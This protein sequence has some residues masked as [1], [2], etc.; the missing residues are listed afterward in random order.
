MNPFNGE[1][2][3]MRDRDLSLESGSH[4]IQKFQTKSLHLASRF[5]FILCD[6]EVSNILG[7]ILGV[8]MTK[9]KML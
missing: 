4:F 1:S 5:V 6:N 8:V 2:V 9:Q 3:D 7:L